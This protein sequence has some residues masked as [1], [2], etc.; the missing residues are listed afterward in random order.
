[1]TAAGEGQ[2]ATFGQLVRY[3]RRQSVDPMRGGML[4]QERL[5]ELIGVQMGDAGYTGA[6]VSEWERDKSKIHADDRLVLLSLL[7]VL[8]QCGGLC[9]PDQADELLA[10][11]NY[12]R[13]DQ[14]ERGLVFE[15][16]EAHVD[17]GEQAVETDMQSAGSLGKAPSRRSKQLILLDKVC[18]FW[19]EGVLNK[20]VQGAP[21][22][23][24]LQTYN[25]EAIDHPWGDI[26]G[27]DLIGERSAV[28]PRSIYETYNQ[29]DSALL[30]LG[31]PGSGK[32]TMLISLAEEMI[33]RAR[34]DWTKPIP[35]ILDLA[36]WARMPPVSYTHLRAHET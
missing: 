9:T 33:A 20:S 6:A 23:D 24:V 25:Y 11:G 18:S 15:N 31:Y 10:A 8:V 4:T 36:S 29:S 17:T 2:S 7:A 3:Y 13:L 26:L 34:A 16:G 30:I 27:S 5:G 12:R 28:P 1:M 14:Q 21:L 32:T 35:V 19:V 22:I